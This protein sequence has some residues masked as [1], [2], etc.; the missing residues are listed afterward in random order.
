MNEPQGQEQVSE[1][2]EAVE[3]EPSEKF[4]KSA[5]RNADLKVPGAQNPESPEIKDEKNPNSE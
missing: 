4:K 3:M 2:E 5:E 1:R